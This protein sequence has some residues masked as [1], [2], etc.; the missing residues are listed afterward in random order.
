MDCQS[1]IARAILFTTKNGD[2]MKKFAPMLLLLAACAPSEDKFEASTIELTCE[3][4][5]EC[6]A[7]EDIAAAEEAGFWFFGADASECVEILTES[8]DESEGAED[9]AASDFVY[10]KDVAKECLAAME[11]MSCEDFS[12]GIPSECEGVYTEE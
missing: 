4:T 12:S 10:N 11:A 2:I 7:E 1:N 6:T 3:K 5:F 8:S 9:T